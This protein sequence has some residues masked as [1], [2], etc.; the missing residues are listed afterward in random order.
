MVID[1]IFIIISGD[2]VDLHICIC[3]CT[4]HCLYLCT[5]IAALCRRCA[6]LVSRRPSSD[7]VSPVC[8][9]DCGSRDRRCVRTVRASSGQ[10]S[11]RRCWIKVDSAVNLGEKYYRSKTLWHCR[12]LSDK[13]C[14]HQSVQVLDAMT[15]D[16]GRHRPSYYVS[17]PFRWC[18]VPRRVPKWQPLAA[19]SSYY[20]WWHSPLYTML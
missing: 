1:C 10:F 17:S 13:R 8:C 20:C 12:E 6:A 5:H 2:G 11:V 15:T 9:R 19:A 14:A 16:A 7:L 4:S 18:H 3:I